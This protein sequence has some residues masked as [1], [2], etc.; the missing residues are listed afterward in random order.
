MARKAKTKKQIVADLKELGDNEADIKMGKADLELLYK[1]VLWKTKKEAEKKEAEK[2]E[3]KEK[4]V[5]EPPKA[6]V[7]PPAP[8]PEV[9]EVVQ[10]QYD[11]KANLVE[12]LKKKGIENV[13]VEMSIAELKTIFNK[14][15]QKDI[16]EKVSTGSLESVNQMIDESINKEAIQLGDGGYIIPKD[17]RKLKREDIGWLKV[18][19]YVLTI[20]LKL[21]PKVNYDIRSCKMVV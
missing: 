19:G 20:V 9:S 12:M 18:R 7:E 1:R 3:V 17:F 16:Q 6:L 10:E 8:I 5:I 15:K 11:Q 14:W 2:K 21:G 4:E 13:N